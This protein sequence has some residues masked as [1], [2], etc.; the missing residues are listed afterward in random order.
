MKIKYL[1]FA[2]LIGRVLPVNAQFP[3]SWVLT[4]P[5]QIMT[6]V[7]VPT[8][9]VSYSNEYTCFSISPNLPLGY[10]WLPAFKIN[11]S[12]NNSFNDCQDLY[13]G[14]TP[15]NCLINLNLLIYPSGQHF[16]LRAQ[17][18]F[19]NGYSSEY[20]YTTFISNPDNDTVPTLTL[21]I[22]YCQY[23]LLD[24]PIIHT[25]RH[26]PFL[27]TTNYFGQNPVFKLQDDIYINGSW[28]VLDTTNLAGVRKNWDVY[29]Q[30]TN[31]FVDLSIT[32]DSTVPSVFFSLKY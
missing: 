12:T 21:S 22:D 5:E 27:T 20:S 9:S 4:L 32:N 25:N 19:M 23:Y 14:C 6:N 29:F 30:G 7:P 2:I 28:Q 13:F 8:A 17:A 24:N 15:T 11:I 10:G 16:Y 31:S 3:P 1:I 18:Y 26:I